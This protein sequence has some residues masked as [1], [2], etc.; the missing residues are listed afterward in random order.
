MEFA[1]SAGLVADALLVIWL[2]HRFLPIAHH[3]ESVSEKVT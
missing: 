2:A 1:I 3:E